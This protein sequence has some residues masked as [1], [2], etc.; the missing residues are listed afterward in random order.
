[1]LILIFVRFKL[2]GGD[3]EE[4]CLWDVILCQLTSTRQH[5]VTFKTLVVLFNLTFVFFV[6]CAQ[7]VEKF[8]G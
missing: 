7:S 5:G 6:F 3:C 4:Y 1:M 8:S 2:S